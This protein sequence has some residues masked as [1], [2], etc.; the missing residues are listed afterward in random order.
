MPDES[1]TLALVIVSDRQ[2]FNLVSEGLALF[3]WGAVQATATAHAL[4]QLGAKKWP[5]IFFSCDSG[6]ANETS[7]AHHLDQRQ[8][9]ALVFM[10]T[11]RSAVSYMD[12]PVRALYKL[13]NLSAG[14]EA[15][16]RKR[17]HQS[18][19]TALDRL[20]EAAEALTFPIPGAQSSP[21]IGR[22]QAMT[23]ARRQVT[24]CAGTS[25][26]VLLTGERNTGK[27]LAAGTIH[28][29]S[30]GGDD[31]PVLLNC[32]DE[33]ADFG[34]P[35]HR[36]LPKIWKSKKRGT[37]LLLDVNHAS[38]ATQATL[39]RHQCGAAKTMRLI[40][41]SPCDLGPLVEQG[42]FSQ[43]L[44]DQ[45]RQ[46]H[47][48]QL[49]PLRERREDIE[50]L[51]PYFA[52]KPYVRISRRAWAAINDYAW[53]GNL[54]ELHNV[55]ISVAATAADVICS[56]DLSDLMRKDLAAKTPTQEECQS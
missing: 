15:Y 39:L 18:I 56:D 45:L 31:V 16:V 9:E 28:K 30:C 4:E 22:S 17:L 27:M 26:P 12:S 36:Q 38:K 35:L 10:L 24:E 52:K 51:I 33:G 47:H 5:L 55:A 13:V 6:D 11:D 48:I 25:L 54:A 21:L 44:Y 29:L 50:L 14:D 1:T 53:P 42:R 3:G 8:A 41:S 37:I 19:S 49:P 34:G 23:E 2:V 40:A 46:T 32:Q 43:A 7:V 20:H